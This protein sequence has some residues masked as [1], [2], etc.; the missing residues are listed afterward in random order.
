LVV[1]CYS[2]STAVMELAYMAEKI[3]IAQSAGKLAT[4]PVG[5]RIPSAASNKEVS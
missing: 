4:A 1:H 2:S 5:V 3:K